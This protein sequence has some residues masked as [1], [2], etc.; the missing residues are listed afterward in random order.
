MAVKLH[1]VLLEKQKETITDVNSCLDSF[2][3]CL[4][5][6]P[7][8][9]GKTYLLIEGFTKPFLDK[10]K[11]KNVVY[12]YPLDIIKTEITAGKKRIDEDGKIVVEESKYLK[13]GKLKIKGKDK[14]IHFISYQ[15]LSRKFN[16][17]Q[18]YWRIYFDEHKI[19]LIILDEAHRAGSSKFY[20]IYD[21]IRDLVGPDGIRILGATATPDRM[22]DS[23]EKLSVLE[24]VF[25]NKKP[26]DY[27]LGEALNDGIV[28]ELVYMA[29]RFTIDDQAQK[30]KKNAQ[31]KFGDAFDEK[32]FN[33]ELGK[34]KQETGDEPNTIMKAI[35]QAGYNPVKEKYYKFIVFFTNIDDMAEQ[36]EDVEKWFNEAF[37]KRIK[38]KYQLKKPFTIRTSYVASNDEDGKFAELVAKR[39]DIRRYFNKTKYVEELIEEDLKV[40]LL[41]TVDMINMGYHVEN[42]TGIM[43][44]RGTKSEIVYYQ[45][46]GR[47]ISVS[48][49]HN[50][51]VIDCVNNLGENF[52]F[53]KNAKHRDSST[54]GAG[55]G[56]PRQHREID[57]NPEYLGSLNMFNR[58]MSRYDCKDNMTERLEFEFLYLDRNMPIYII[59]ALKKLTCREVV[60]LLI[61]YEIP[62]K[63]ED[64]EYQ[65]LMDKCQDFVKAGNKEKFKQEAYK[66]KF[67]N[68]KEATYDGA[69][70]YIKNK[71]TYTMYDMLNKR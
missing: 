56:E 63:Q 36:A 35:E 22:D 66:F 15:E 55:T 1:P 62:I 31:Q 51:I 59:A 60:K 40:D 48:A 4:M 13:D 19:G 70:P 12:V 34:L 67:I 32:S 27:G 30:I 57:I 17:N 41:F 29:D 46:L 18:D 33:V 39:P 47:A 7:T 52:W 11:D 53:K 28:P 8:G 69:C 45:Q 54:D 14:N 3:R 42:I 21:N 24:Y 68:C 5:I 44:R 6:R 23:D 64:K 50:P 2:G 20:E 26:F 9:F 16:E 43:M 58:F 37:N 10:H 61:K 71:Q 49:S 38:E 25:D 65:R